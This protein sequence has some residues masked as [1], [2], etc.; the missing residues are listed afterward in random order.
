MKN[1]IRNTV[2]VLNLK[3]IIL[4]KLN[5]CSIPGHVI[6]LMY[7]TKGTKTFMYPV[8]KHTYSFINK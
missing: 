4:I 2:F 7:Y 8:T 6:A 3:I 5:W 1:I